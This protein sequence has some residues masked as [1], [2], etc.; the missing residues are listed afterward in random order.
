MQFNRFTVCATL[1]IPVLLSIGALIK[2]PLRPVAT[3]PPLSSA[4]RLRS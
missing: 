4:V 3:A 1:A 2:V